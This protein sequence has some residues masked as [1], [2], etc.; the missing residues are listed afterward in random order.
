MVQKRAI[1]RQKQAGKQVSRSGGNSHRRL[2]I[3]GGGVA[4][5]SREETLELR[6]CCH[7]EL[8]F[9]A[10]VNS[11][12]RYYPGHESKR[13]GLCKQKTRA[14]EQ[15]VRFLFEQAPP[16]G[17]SWTPEQGAAYC[18]DKDTKRTKLL[19]KQLG[20]DYHLMAWV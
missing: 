1:K 10:P 4:G 17:V 20:Y 8:T 11:R 6:K 16:H 15:A 7:C 14:L 2:P 13:S 3:D 19:M 18:I 9:L 12:R 5:N